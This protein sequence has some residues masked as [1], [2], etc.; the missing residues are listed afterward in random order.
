MTWTDGH[1]RRGCYWRLLTNGLFGYDCHAADDCTCEPELKQIRAVNQP[2]IAC[3]RDP[4]CE[5]SGGLCANVRECGNAY[6]AYLADNQPQEGVN[7]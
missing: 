1:T 7:R 4:E 6:P 5:A 2:R 3:T